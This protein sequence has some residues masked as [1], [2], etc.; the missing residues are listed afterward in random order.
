MRHNSVYSVAKAKLNQL[1]KR[2]DH[3][4]KGLLKTSVCV[5]YVIKLSA[6]VPSTICHNDLFPMR[7]T[8]VR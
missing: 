4:Q 3:M 2:T 8:A 7:S 5:C 1:M 6:Q